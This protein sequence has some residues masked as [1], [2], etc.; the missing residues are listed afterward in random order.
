MGQEVDLVR[1][2]Y[3]RNEI[4]AIQVGMTASPDGKYV[5]FAF[6]DKVVRVFDVRA[7]KF[8]KRLTI[9][10]TEVFDMHLTNDGKL[11]VMQVKDV[12]II[13]WKGE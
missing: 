8:V 10:F 6:K 4:S 12:L 9:P 2:G 3:L 1:L 11:V 13:D 5:A 7:G